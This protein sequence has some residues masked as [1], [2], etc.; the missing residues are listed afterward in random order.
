MRL[1]EILG[2][3][4]TQLLA[5]AFLA[6]LILSIRRHH[7]AWKPLIGLVLCF[8]NAMLFELLRYHTFSAHDALSRKELS[9]FAQIIKDH[10]LYP[11][12][13]LTFLSALLFY[14]FYLL[15][16]ARKKSG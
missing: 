2:T 1:L 12:F 8:V 7:G 3:F 14:F 16:Y 10:P 15:R 4:F 13:Y 6:L 5:V 11:Y 9:I